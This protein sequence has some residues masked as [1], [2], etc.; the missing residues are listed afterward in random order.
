MLGPSSWGSFSLIPETRGDC[1]GDIWLTSLDFS[2][3]AAL[4]RAAEAA[5]VGL[6]LSNSFFPSR[7]SSI[8]T[9][10][11]PKWHWMFTEVHR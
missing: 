1:K 3:N 10:R 2:R 8:H 7:Q 4:L 9:G 5:I 6:I 11:G